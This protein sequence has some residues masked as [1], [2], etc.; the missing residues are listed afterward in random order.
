MFHTEKLI[1][2][3]GE[4]FHPLAQSHKEPSPDGKIERPSTTCPPASNGR[5]IISLD[6]VENIVA[7]KDLDF[8]FSST[9]HMWALKEWFMCMEISL[10]PLYQVDTARASASTTQ[11]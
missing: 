3:P 1:S 8:K 7:I 6:K 10:T 9:K 4:V 2:I 11:D 5:L